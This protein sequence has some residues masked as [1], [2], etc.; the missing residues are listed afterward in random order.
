MAGESLPKEERPTSFR[1]AE[2][3]ERLT[4]LEFLVEELGRD[5]G[6]RDLRIDMIMETQMKLEEI[7]NKISRYARD[8]RF[9]LIGAGTVSMIMVSG[10]DAVIKS[11]FKLLLLGV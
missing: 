5:N 9:L 6:R 3:W 10:F 11:G 2:D 8:I 7:Q 1:R 4:K